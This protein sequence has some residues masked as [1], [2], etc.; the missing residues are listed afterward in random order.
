[1]YNRFNEEREKQGISEREK[2]ERS[3]QLRNWIPYKGF[4]LESEWRGVEEL[5]ERGSKLFK[6]KKQVKFN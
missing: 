5:I 6:G 1:M 2:V 3:C 4:C